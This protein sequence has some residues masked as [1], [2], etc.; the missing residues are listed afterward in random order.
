MSL[1][2]VDN[3]E[4]GD[5]RPINNINEALITAD[6]SANVAVPQ[7]DDTAENDLWCD[8]C[9]DQRMPFASKISL[10]QHL[11]TEHNI[12]PQ[13]MCHLC[14]VII[15]NQPQMFWHIKGIHLHDVSRFKLVKCGVVQQTSHVD[16]LSEYG[17]EANHYPCFY[18]RQTFRVLR[19]WK[20]H[21]LNC[22]VAVERSRYPIEGS[23]KQAVALSALEG[24]GD[25]GL[26]MK[27]E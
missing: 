21:V 23:A 3:P 25:E 2:F 11:S 24:V 6:G 10:V 1:L 22:V 9:E 12:H 5:H 7:N 20:L 14:G 26:E 4:N 8:L 18:C 27:G 15:C 13:F 19:D 16:V 17:H